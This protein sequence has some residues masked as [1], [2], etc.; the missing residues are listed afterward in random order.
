[1]TTKMS[2]MSAD[3][4]AHSTGITAESLT[5]LSFATIIAYRNGTAHTERSGAGNVD[6]WRSDF[7][8]LSH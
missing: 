6:S 5:P 7:L 3:A 8:R 2:P 1:V 4:Q